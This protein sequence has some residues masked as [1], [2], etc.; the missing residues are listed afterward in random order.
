MPAAQTLLGRL[1]EHAAER[2]CSP[3]YQDPCGGTLTYRDLADAADA[4]ATTLRAA[5]RPGA[6]VILCS[7]NRIEY[8]IAFLAVLAAGCTVFPLSA[9]ASDAELSRAALESRASAA[10][11][12]ERAI[13]I[14][15]HDTYFALHIAAVR[16]PVPL[17]ANRK[18]QIAN[19]SPPALLLQSSGTTGLPKIARRTIDSLDAV[20]RAMA[21][22]IRFSPDDRVLMTVPLTH[23]YGLEH[24]LLAPVW[25]GSRVHLCRGIDPSVTLPQLA[26][27]GITVFPA[28]PATFEILCGP[29]GAGLTMPT[30]RVAYA[31]GAALPRSVFDAFRNRFGILIAQLYGATEIGSV[32][33]NPPWEE[34]FDP[35]SVGLPMQGISIHIL[36][37]DTDQP[38]PPGNQG[39]V[40]IRAD[41]MFSGYLTAAPDLIDGHY[42]NGDL[43]YLDPTGRLFI[44]G[45]IKLLI[46]IGGMKVN[47]LEVEAVLTR[48]PSVA[49]CVV[50]AVRQSETVNRLKAVIQPRDPA[51]PPPIKDLRRLARDHLATH[52]VPRIFQFRD[53]LPLS[54]TGKVLRHLVEKT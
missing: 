1:R 14:L 2:P 42:P 6:V 47:P 20:S 10:L 31:A 37:V 21:E 29:T 46:D 24:G 34:P 5:L 38:L 35:A 44:T 8:P 25:A 36:D 3:A 33:F 9:D 49:A 22:A 53:S 54:P 13:E 12:D 23:S 45:R 50:V 11:G 4:L 43:G 52:K 19:P 48:H 15:I 28:V 18:L 27:G 51:A 39:Q 16:N 41:S 40:A 30:L 7:H 17:I 26:G 32:T